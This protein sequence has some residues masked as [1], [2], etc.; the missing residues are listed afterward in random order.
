MDLFNLAIKAE[1]KEE[2]TLAPVAAPWIPEASFAIKAEDGE[3][4]DNGVAF[5]LIL[6]RPEAQVAALA[7]GEAA[8]PVYGDE[9]EAEDLKPAVQAFQVAPVYQ[10]VKFK[11]GEESEEDSEGEEPGPPSK[12]RTPMAWDPEGRGLHRPLGPSKDQSR[13][14]RPCS[15]ARTQSFTLLGKHSGLWLAFTPTSKGV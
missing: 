2:V 9:E 7:Y 4:S 15:L 5:A 1:V 3:A 11:P 10:A 12:K 13:P 8:S 14:R 6:Y